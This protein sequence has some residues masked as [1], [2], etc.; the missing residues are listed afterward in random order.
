MDALQ[1]LVLKKIETVISDDVND[2]NSRYLDTL[3]R[4]HSSLFWAS[5]EL[6]T[7]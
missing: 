5:E 4:L 7:K 3:T 1:I 2:N 6:K